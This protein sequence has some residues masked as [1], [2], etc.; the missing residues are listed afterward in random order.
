MRARSR[1]L[2]RLLSI[3]LFL[4]L[5]LLVK[6]QAYTTPRENQ[7]RVR[8]KLILLTRE[9]E[10]LAERLAHHARDHESRLHAEQKR[11]KKGN[12][13]EAL[14]DSNITARMT[15]RTFAQAAQA[16]TLQLAATRRGAGPSKQQAAGGYTAPLSHRVM[17]PKGS[18]TSR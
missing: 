2:A 11:A 13:K 17:V 4:S 10:D 15:A 9:G 6:Q 18:M 7:A 3:L 16:T 5:F 8:A 12:L 1:S 14:H